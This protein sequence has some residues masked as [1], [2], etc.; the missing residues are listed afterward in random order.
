MAIFSRWRQS[1]IR[2]FWSHIIL[3]MI[4][5]GFGMPG[6]YAQGTEKNSLQEATNHLTI[7]KA[8]CVDKLCSQLSSS[9]R[10]ASTVDYWQREALRKVIRRLS[11]VLRP[12]RFSYVQQDISTVHKQALADNLTALLTL[13]P[14]VSATIAFCQ[15]NKYLLVDN[16]Q[17]SEFIFSRIH[18][19]RAGPAL[20]A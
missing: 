13:S 2:Y 11:S 10:S 6:A 3:G 15:T 16:D 7:N 14:P 8:I 18:G 17:L 12:Q 20:L 1:G 9:R 4:A 19:I 5:A